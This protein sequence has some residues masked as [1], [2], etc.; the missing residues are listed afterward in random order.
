MPAP[1]PFQLALRDEWT[2]SWGE[3]N[4]NS[5]TLVP[6]LLITVV[7]Q[8]EQ[9]SDITFYELDSAGLGHLVGPTVPTAELNQHA[10]DIQG[11]ARVT[12]DWLINYDLN[13]QPDVTLPAGTAV[14]MLWLPGEASTYIAFVLP[15]NH[16]PQYRLVQL[17]AFESYTE[18]T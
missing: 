14:A 11:Y 9:S 8:D 5:F 17:A 18:A 12:Q 16:A 3:D 1:V 7:R 13:G 2:F 4:A 15:P 10:S 6:P